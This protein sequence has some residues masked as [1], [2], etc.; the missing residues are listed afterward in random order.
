[1]HLSMLTTPTSA[2][3]ANQALV[4]V[5]E[6]KF[7][8]SKHV[9]RKYASQHPKNNLQAEHTRG[10]STCSPAGLSHNMP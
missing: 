1:M 6:E 3:Y 10:T 4:L 8:T 7:G 2:V 9:A 5:I